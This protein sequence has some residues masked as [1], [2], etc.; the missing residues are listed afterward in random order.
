ML[1]NRIIVLLILF[2]VVSP[3]MLNAQC[4]D[5][6]HQVIDD[7]YDLPIILEGS[8]S[9][10]ADNFVVYQSGTSEILGG[11]FTNDRIYK[12][13][14]DSVDL[15]SDGEND[16]GI[17]LFVD[18]CRD[19]V[20]FDASI[21]I[22][23]ADGIDCE[24]VDQDELYTNES[25]FGGY[26][27]SIDAGA[28][29]PSAEFSPPNYLPIARDIYLDEPGDYYLV[30]DGHSEDFTGDYEMLIGEMSY[31]D[32]VV[33]ASN[34]S[35]VNVEF[36]DTL[37]GVND[38]LYGENNEK[39]WTQGSILNGDEYFEIKDENGLNV[40]FGELR[41]V[42]GNLLEPDSGYS[43]IKFELIDQ[44]DY[45]ASI[46]LTVK[47]HIFAMLDE[48]GDTTN[49]TTA[50]H[51]INSAGIPFS[52]GDT[53]Y[54]DLFDIEPPSITIEGISNEND[55]SIVDPNGNIFIYSSEEL[56]KDQ[57]AISEENLSD[58]ISLSFLESGEPVGFSITVSEG[59]RVIEIDP[60]NSLDNY[61][62][63][64]LQI[65]LSDTN[66]SGVSLND[67]SGNEITTK[68]S[69]IRI[70]D[71]EDPLFNSAVIDSNSNTL[72]TI[73]MSEEIYKDYADLVAS[74]GLDTSHFE[75]AITNNDLNNIQTVQ[76]E[77]VIKV[78]SFEPAQGGEDTLR[79]QLILDPP[80]ASGSETITISTTFYPIYDR[81]GNQVLNQIT[82]NLK[83]ELA[84]TL[85]VSPSPDNAIFPSS[86]I[87]LS[88]SETVKSYNEDNK[89]ISNLNEDIFK[90]I[91]RLVNQ[92]GDFLDYQTDFG[93]DTM[94]I[95]ID[96]VDLLPELET[97]YLFINGSSL[98]DNDTNLTGGYSFE[99]EVADITPP[100]FAADSF[101]RGNDY[102]MIQMS[103]S[104][105][106]NI[107]ATEPLT[108][109]DFD[110][111]VNEHQGADSIYIKSIA[112]TSGGTPAIGET[113]FRLNLKVIGSANG[114][115]S[116]LVRPKPNEIYDA[117]GNNL[118]A[119][120]ETE[121]FDLLPSP[122]FNQQNSSLSLD[123]EF[124]LVFDNGPVFSNKNSSSFLVVQDFKVLLSYS[125]EISELSPFDITLE[126][127][128]GNA[129]E[130]GDEFSEYDGED[131]VKLKM[132]LDFTPTGGE[133][134]RIFPESS[135]AIYN[136]NG[137]NMDSLEFAGPFT[138]NDQLRPF[139][140]ANITN[141]S[142][143]ISYNDTLIFSF[144]ERVKL[145]DG[146]LDGNTAEGCFKLFDLSRYEDGSTP[147]GNIEIPLDSAFEYLTFHT[148]TND[149]D[150]DSIWVIM[151]QP[152]GSEHTMCL[153][154]KD[155]FEDFAGNQ[156][157]KGDTITFT[158]SDNI[159]PD[160]IAGSVKIDEDLYLSLQDNPEASRKICAVNLS[161]NDNV[162]TDS[163]EFNAITGDNFSVEVIQNN[164]F[165]SSANIE[166]IELFEHSDEGKD[167]I[168]LQLKFDEVP[169]SEEQFFIRPFNNKAIYDLNLNTMSMDSTSDTL[170]TYDLR[171]PS[172]DS[173]DIEH[174]GFVDLVID[175]VISIYFSE[176]IDVESF[177]YKFTSKLDISGFGHT[178]RLNPDTLF[179][180]LDSTI[181]SY[182]T[183][184]LEVLY[185]RDTSGNVRDSL[186]SRRFFT[187]AA[188]DF[189][190]PPDDRIS[191][192]DLDIFKSGWESNDFSRNLGP[193]TGTPPNIKI[194]QDS[195]FGIDDGMAFTQMWSWSLQKHGPVEIIDQAIVP[196]QSSLLQV[197][198]NRVS[199]LPIGEA[200]YGQIILDYGQNIN[201]VHP[202]ENVQ[203]QSNGGILLKNINEVDGIAVIEFVS[204]EKLTSSIGF[205]F[206]RNINEDIDIRIK[207]AFFDEDY[208]L[209]DQKDSVI[210]RIYIPKEF[211]LMQNYP[212]P[213]NPKTNIRFTLPSDSFVKLFIYDINGRVV[214]EIIHSNMVSGYY[215]TV[216]DGTNTIGAQVGSGVYFCR[217]QAGEFSSSQKLI[218]LK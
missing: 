145:L 149:P 92:N 42:S 127:E 80:Y 86:D 19:N 89:I 161:I 67:E 210:S 58:Y 109:Q 159:A 37:Y 52:V 136:S 62:W 75:L 83:D 169:S 53:M 65:T 171:F 82:F 13:T 132:N 81:A 207:Y 111:W 135:N 33:V 99:Y 71:T 142:M 134:V 54:I 12:F 88:F 140:S 123:N 133:V 113:I 63:V 16:L 44:P 31:F 59:S 60:D 204:S 66:A 144:N 181:M 215:T 48:N 199:I 91:V 8:T 34:N 77:N 179:L 118:S 153:I 46:S 90:T 116:V 196:D 138:L 79:L 84:P 177:S 183:L 93:T 186:L 1:S 124:F 43:A 18:M 100:S 105:F 157:L 122:I 189:S 4:D 107:E 87:T 216:W 14:I 25:F 10:S 27:E 137:V 180:F 30:V 200:R 74:G 198:N 143:N 185:I 85:E 213:F 201:S 119:T 64:D 41:D 182:D 72:V 98:C 5:K 148:E 206:E 29:C 47:D 175:S 6:V 195:I 192:E 156:I 101:G 126:D 73:S 2:S 32:S 163:T 147:E 69:N 21:A 49:Q 40:S 110:L 78:D 68:T 165:V 217:I 102:I 187:K 51:L 61:Q 9:E 56:F 57:E 26:G 173:T 205:D 146:N 96:P 218:L 190:D 38:N 108:T 209:I 197:S 104:V 176:P 152:F 174:E 24:N 150:P 106:S 188:G 114:T 168:R 166:S 35:W 164:G 211:S 141:E 155:N 208:S 160:F 130:S 158:T 194:I 76:V 121:Q 28:L 125:G 167:S 129:L 131:I 94:E 103:E 178:F 191:L 70:N 202:L 45:G 154:I 112:D 7:I 15:D 214:N 55:P 22:V 128:N 3:I 120:E 39:I 115:E 17:N 162:F 212:N 11:Y 117:G 139:Y 193:Y 23:K 50:P 172:I 170:F 203:I 184:D 97:V 20:N 95:T 151:R 36:S